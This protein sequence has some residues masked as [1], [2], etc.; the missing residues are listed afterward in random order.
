MISTCTFYLDNAY[1]I[2]NNVRNL[3]VMSLFLCFAY[4]T[5]CTYL[6]HYLK[7]LHVNHN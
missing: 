7:Y 5:D 4:Q 6:K 1:T 3:T 2:Q